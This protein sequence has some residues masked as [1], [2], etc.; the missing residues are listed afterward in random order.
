MRSTGETAFIFV[1]WLAHPYQVPGPEFRQC[2]Q[3]GY[4]YV[5]RLL[6][7]LIITLDS[8]PRAMNVRCLSAS[9]SFS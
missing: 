1:V 5:V 2:R 4:Q 9:L 6:V 7:L 8:Q 3:F